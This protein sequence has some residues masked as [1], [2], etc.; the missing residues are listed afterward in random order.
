MGRNH[1]RA[2]RISTRACG[3]INSLWKTKPP[4]AQLTE[5]RAVTGYLSRNDLY[6]VSG[7]ANTSG[8]VLGV[9]PN[10]SEV[11]FLPI[12]E[13]RFIDATDIAERRRVVVLGSKNALLLFLGHP[14]LGE[15]ITIND[16][17]FTVVGRAEPVSH[18]NNDSENQKIYIPLA[19]MDGTLRHEGRQRGAGR[20]EFHSIS[21]REEGRRD[22]CRSGG[23]SRDCRAPRIRPVAHGRVRG[24]ESTIHTQQMIAAIFNGMDVFLGSVGLVT[25]GLGAVGIIN[26][27]LVSV[28]ERTQEI[29]VMKAGAGAT[30]SSILAQFFWEGLL[31]T[32]ISGLIGVAL[33]GAFMA[34]L[35]ETLTGKMPGWDP[36]RLV[37]WS[38]ALAV[39]SLAICGIVAGLYPAS[40][41]A[42]LDPIEALR[43]E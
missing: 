35:Q 26:I 39:G 43:K 17:A 25:L 37:P 4:C 5:L 40:K 30:R 28:T 34:L 8:Q 9:E 16:I 23:A 32:G 33:S 1:S 36:P 2:V 13:G 24:A 3:P 10:Y 22:G 41:A 7:Y 27:M 6:Q 15:T 38:A 29:G 42:A 19:T 31:L 18:G 12:A 20:A 14:I 11:R 21:T